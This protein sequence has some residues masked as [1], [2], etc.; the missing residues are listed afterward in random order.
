MVSAESPHFAEIFQ[1]SLQG[2]T[3]GRVAWK[4]QKVALALG[5]VALRLGN[6]AARL[7][8]VASRL[9]HVASRHGH[10][11]SRPGALRPGVSSV[12]TAVQVATAVSVEAEGWTVMSLGLVARQAMAAQA[13][14]GAAQALGL[15]EAPLPAVALMSAVTERAV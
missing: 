10:V 4:L 6:V 2:L 14:V 1:T 3:P 11:A 9:R 12:A 7:R 8:N 15:A 13:L 5:N